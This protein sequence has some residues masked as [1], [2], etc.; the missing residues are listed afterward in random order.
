[1]AEKK[2]VLIRINKE[3][4]EELQRLAAQE[5][6]SVNGQ[7]EFVLREGVVRRGRRPMSK[8]PV[9]EASSEPQQ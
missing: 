3:L 5:L 4:W 1:M 8:R 6:R 2:A 9:G 7:I